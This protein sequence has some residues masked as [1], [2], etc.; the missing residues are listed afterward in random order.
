MLI[1][2]LI[3]SKSLLQKY[4]DCK[5]RGKHDTS[6]LP[7][8]STLRLNPSQR[9]PFFTE[10]GYR[11]SCQQGPFLLNRGIRSYFQQTIG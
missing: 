6:S 8:G 5:K 11:T 7:L 9:N 1:K 4:R 2:T 10:Q 3:I